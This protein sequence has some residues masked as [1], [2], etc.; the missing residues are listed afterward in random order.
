MMTRTAI[1]L[2]LLLPAAALPQDLDTAA[3]AVVQ[4]SGIRNGST[5]RGSG[6]V[7]G[8]DRD[9][10]TI[11]TVSHVIA[12]LENIQV[13]FAADLTES[14]PAGGFL[15]MDAENPKGPAVFQVRGAI[16][17]GVTVLSFEVEKRPRLGEPL[18]LL[19]FPLMAT[20]LRTTQRTL[21]ARDGTS[22][23]IDQ[24]LGEGFSGG[25]VL[26][27]G[28]VVGV[29]TGVDDQTTYAV[30][31]VVVR[32]A[33]E[34]WGVRL[35]G[36]APDPPPAEAACVPGQSVTEDGIDYVRI[37]SGTFTMGSAKDD[38][39]AYADEKPAHRVRLSEFRI[40][41]TEVTN[42]QYRRVQ[43]D[44]K[45]EDNL[46]AAKV[47]WTEAK[48]ACE[49]FGGRLPTEA[50]WEYAA[51]AGSTTAWSFAG[52]ENSLSDYA[53]FNK[54][55]GDTTHPVAT[56]KPNAWGLYDLHGNV[57]EWVADWYAPY[58]AEAQPDPAGP[59]TGESRVL[60]GGV[61]DG[62]PRVLRSAVRVRVRPG[63]RDRFIGFRCARDSGQ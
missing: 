42:A 53:W 10:A 16:P 56:K 25:P 50:E 61:F 35:G 51:R 36:Q 60:R 12:G 44:H 5:V 38:P 34:G 40:G 55:A 23:L 8:L 39:Q 1:L 22:L 48:A 26:Q 49:H 45:G 9:K 6:F 7:V 18:Y 52:D 2:F 17:A 24:G 33:L 63:D 4:I 31:A 19:G 14:F 43:P 57:W 13:T 28:K 3:A 47:S 30:E 59:A 27:N 29:V 15:R 62:P 37:C 32:A 11:V 20:S 54:N 21:S 58:T 41:K 46:P